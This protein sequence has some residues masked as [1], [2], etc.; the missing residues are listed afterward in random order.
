MNFCKY[1][2]VYTKGKEKSTVSSNIYGFS[3]ISSYTFLIPSSKF[4]AA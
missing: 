2:I 3:A 1:K 4:L